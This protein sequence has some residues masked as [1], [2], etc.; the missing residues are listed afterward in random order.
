[1][2][3]IGQILLWCGFLSGA[4]AAVIHAPPAGVTHVLE[5]VKPE[6]VP[7]MDFPDLSGVEV[8]EDGWHLIPWGWYGASFV[9]CLVG[10]VLIRV[11]RAAIQSDPQ[12]HLS[13]SEELLN[14]LQ[15]AANKTG[16]LATLTEQLPPSK[17]TA[18]IDHEIADHLR[19][20]ADGRDR[21]TAEFDLDTFADVMSPFAAG[22]RAVNRAWSAA[23]DGYVD[24]AAICL[25]RGHLMLQEAHRILAGAC[26]Q[27][28]NAP[29]APV[30]KG[31]PS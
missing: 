18:T 19:E 22:E 15:E 21:I 4:L 9:V 28:P 31:T 8:P 20:F 16:R 2:R 13:S 14:A 23:A 27:D 30:D 26:Q 5:D 24:E 29:F 10:V 17:I 6:D 3:T 1:M 25:N 7:K 12:Q 11:S